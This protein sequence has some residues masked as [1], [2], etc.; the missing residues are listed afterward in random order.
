MLIHNY[1]LKIMLPDCNPSSEKVNAIA[2]FSDDISDLLPYL[3]TVLKGVQY[4]EKE[5]I[6]IVKREGHLITFRPKKIAI[7]KLEDGEDA[8]TVM[9]DLKHIINE[10][11]QN[12]EHIKPDYSSGKE[13]NASD[14]N[15]LLPGT[16]CKKCGERS[17]FAFAFKLA[18]QEGAILQ[19]APFFSDE[20]REKR[21]SLLGLLRD[22]GYEVLEEYLES[23]RGKGLR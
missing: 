21:K 12:R 1:T 2:D 11:Y 15:R 5:R 6:L 17:C 10:T 19:C 3:N 18:R 7:T 9:E 8:R 4:I 22:S 13:L 23:E 20:Y 14:I 16:N